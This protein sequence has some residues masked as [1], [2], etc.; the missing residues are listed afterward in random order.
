MTQLHWYSQVSPTQLLQHVMSPAKSQPV[1][2]EGLQARAAHSVEQF[3]TKQELASSHVGFDGQLRL[4][5]AH[6]AQ[7]PS[8]AVSSGQHSFAIQVPQR[9]PSTGL[10]GAQSGPLLRQAAVGPVPPVPPVGA[11]SPQLET[12]TNELSWQPTFSVEQ[13]ATGTSLP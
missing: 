3:A 1:Q 13:L 7:G 12:F 6:E 11:V 2:V 8:H 9:A 10:S 4:S 5:S